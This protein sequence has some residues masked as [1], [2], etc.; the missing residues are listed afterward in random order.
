MRF[1]LVALTLGLFVSLTSCAGY[2]F[3]GN[4]PAHLEAVKSIY[5]PLAESRAVFPRI[6]ALT[7]NSI[8]DALVQDGSYR[9]GTSSK[10]DA[11]LLITLDSLSYRQARSSSDDV[12]R[13]EELRLEVTVSYQLLDPTRPGVIL[14]EGKGRGHTRLFVG[15]NL[16]TARV[17]A[18]PDA[19]QRA[20]QSIIARLADGI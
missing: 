1:L 3:G 14:D 19:L 5:V 13:S 2:H 18:L 15:D 7:T 12:L 20:S 4:K 11:T 17:N 10:S 9:L 6:E 8:V 16:Q